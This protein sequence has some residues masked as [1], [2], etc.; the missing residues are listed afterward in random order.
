MG[1]P[2]PPAIAVEGRRR[3]DADEEEARKGREGKE[4]KMKN[5][6]GCGELFRRNCGCGE[7]SRCGREFHYGGPHLLL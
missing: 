5:V 7:L 3:L 4:K 1:P 2:S 6:C